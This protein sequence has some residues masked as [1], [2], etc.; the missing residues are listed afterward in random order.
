LKYTVNF[1]LMCL[2]YVAFNMEPVKRRPNWSEKETLMLVR[3]ERPRGCY[4]THFICLY[5]DV[6]LEWK[7][8]VYS[9]LKAWFL[10]IF[11]WAN[12][13]LFI[14]EATSS[15]QNIWNCFWF[16]LFI[17][18]LCCYEWLIFQWF[19]IFRIGFPGWPLTII[20]IILKLKLS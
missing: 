10:Y 16:W 11:G 9:L 18:S 7:H 4:W 17:C 20:R 13:S 2:N 1:Y 6:Y 19:F 15:H 5:K 3:G 12:T 8:F 14:M